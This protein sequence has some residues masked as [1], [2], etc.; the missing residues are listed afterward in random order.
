MSDEE[1]GGNDF[2]PCCMCAYCAVHLPAGFTSKYGYYCTRFTMTVDML[3]GCT[4]GAQGE[5]ITGTRAP[6]VNIT[7][8]AAVY[9]YHDYY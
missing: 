9:G 5:P 4:F 3:D 7:E 2:V 8:H 1:V 6:D